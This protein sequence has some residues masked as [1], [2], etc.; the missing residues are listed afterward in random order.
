MKIY[1]VKEKITKKAVCDFTYAQS[2]ETTT[3]R[4]VI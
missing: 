4:Q 1:A 2:N 3:I